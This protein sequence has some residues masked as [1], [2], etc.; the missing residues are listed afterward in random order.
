MIIPATPPI[1][2][3][4]QNTGGTI[5]GSPLTLGNSMQSDVPR[6]AAIGN[7]PTN[8]VP[9]AFEKSRTENHNQ[10]NQSQ[11]QNQKPNGQ[12]ATPQSPQ[13]LAQAFARDSSYYTPQLASDLNRFYHNSKDKEQQYNT[14]SPS[15]NKDTKGN[16]VSKTA[17]NSSQIFLN[18]RQ[19]DK[20]KSSPHLLKQKVDKAIQAYNYTSNHVSSNIV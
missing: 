7:I 20:E 16:E 19:K 5:N 1:S 4:V 10:S 13:F 8:V 9:M 18:E 11:T 12:S 14:T 3:S 6:Q 2:V 15:Q 17:P